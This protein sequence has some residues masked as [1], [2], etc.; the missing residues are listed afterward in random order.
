MI[1]AGFPFPPMSPDGLRFGL[2]ARCCQWFP[3]NPD[4]QPFCFADPV[5]GRLF[6]D[7]PVPDVARDRSVAVIICPLCTV[8]AGPLRDRAGLPP[9][10]VQS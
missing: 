8:R 9:L 7:T 4:R 3:L 5:T 10:P 1:P 6:Y 2:C